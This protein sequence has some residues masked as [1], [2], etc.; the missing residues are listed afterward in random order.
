MTTATPPTVRSL[1]P[2]FGSARL[3]APTVGRA[4]AGLHY[5]AV[6]FAGSMPE[7]L[8]VDARTVAVNDANR[9]QI[10]LARAVARDH[11]GIVAIL[12]AVPY[13]PDALAEARQRLKQD[14]ATDFF[15]AGASGR[16][17]A[18]FASC[19]MVR[20]ETVGTRSQ[21]GAKLSVRYSSTGGGSVVR[22]RSAVESL[23]AWAGVLKRCQFSSEDAFSFIAKQQDR[24]RHGIYC[25]PPF[26]DAG[27]PYLNTFTEADHRRLAD[28]L[29][30]FDRA[31]VVCRFYDHP[32]VRALYAAEH[33][34][35]S[36]PSGG[37]NQNNA[38]RNEV[39]LTL[40]NRGAFPCSAAIAEETAR[41]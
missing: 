21:A 36:F 14:T 3:V 31:R 30:R 41:D 24:D 26:P 1:T 6:P 7:L 22:F 16:A 40:D 34:R 18:Y 17:A 37:R 20:S 39:L 2:Y 10:D 25:D 15:P 27:R 9:E 13:H 35:W 11:A 19:W 23:D 28:D 12:D 29:L 4:L 38:A 8:H 33:W 5:V 32:L